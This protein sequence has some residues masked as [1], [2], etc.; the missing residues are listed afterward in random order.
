MDGGAVIHDYGI[1]NPDHSGTEREGIPH[2]A[3]VIVDGQGIV[4]FV[5]VWVN[6]RERTSPDEILEQIALLAGS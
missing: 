5:N 3:T 1:P 4:R 2:P 6:Y